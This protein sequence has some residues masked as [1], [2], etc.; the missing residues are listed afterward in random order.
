MLL[1]KQLAC[2]HIDGIDIIGDAGLDGHLFHAAAGVHLLDDE[3]REQRMHLLRHIVQF[4]LPKDLQVLD[5]V[6]CQDL[7][8]LLP[9]GPLG[10]CRI[11]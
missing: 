3:R 4:D 11:R 10:V 7:F 1:P 6:F 8:V 2:L 5:V 9:V